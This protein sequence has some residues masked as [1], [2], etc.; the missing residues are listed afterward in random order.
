MDID[1]AVFYEVRNMLCPK[2]GK[3]MEHG[4]LQVGPSVGLGLF[5]FDRLF[6]YGQQFI[7]EKKRLMQIPAPR[8]IEGFRCPKCKIVM[9]EYGLRRKG[10][11]GGAEGV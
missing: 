7:A 11:G 6:E 2:C 4:Y 1:E 9:F 3:E 10:N 5:W 8:N